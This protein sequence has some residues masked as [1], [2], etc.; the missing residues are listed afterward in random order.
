MTP[1]GVVGVF[2]ESPPPLPFTVPFTERCENCTIPCVSTQRM[3]N[4]AKRVCTLKTL[5]NM[6]V[7]HVFGEFSP[8]LWIWK[9]R[10][11]VPSVT[12]AARSQ[13]C[14]EFWL[15]PVSKPELSTPP[16]FDC[17][18][19]CQQLTDCDQV[20]QG[21]SRKSRRGERGFSLICSRAPAIGDPRSFNEANH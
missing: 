5:E 10:V 9:S 18:T 2:P 19:I 4:Y 11:Q 3:L 16:H 17:D 21:I 14:R 1:N 13:A 12:L 7:R 8:R 6:V 15:P 20:L